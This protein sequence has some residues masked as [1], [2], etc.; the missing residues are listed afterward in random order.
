MNSSY[1]RIAIQLA[2]VALIAYIV[3]RQVAAEDYASESK[4]DKT[5]RQAYGHV[6]GSKWGTPLTVAPMGDDYFDLANFAPAR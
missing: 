3:A 5:Q 6:S 1:V 4:R 2:V